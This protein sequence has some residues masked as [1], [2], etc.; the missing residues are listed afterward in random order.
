MSWRPRSKSSLTGA[1]RVPQPLVALVPNHSWARAAA[2][3][4]Q[5]G[6]FFNAHCEGLLISSEMWED[7]V[8]SYGAI[9]GS[10]SPRISV[11]M[12]VAYT[13][14]LNLTSLTGV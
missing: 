4:Y 2:I 3:L 11:G 9:N 10:V 6:E 8:C 12:V 5:Y 1:D 7:R 14:L 13:S